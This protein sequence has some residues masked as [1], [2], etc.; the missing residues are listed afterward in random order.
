MSHENHYSSLS[1][2][3]ESVFKKELMD[4]LPMEA[5]CVPLTTCNCQPDSLA[6]PMR[7]IPFRFARRPGNRKETARFLGHR[8]GD[9]LT[10]PRTL[11]CDTGRT[12]LTLHHARSKCTSKETGCN[13]RPFAGRIP[14]SSHNPKRSLTWDRGLEMAG[15]GK[16]Y[17]SDGRA[18]LLCDP[19]SPWQHGTKETPSAAAANIFLEAPT[20]PDSQ[21]ALDHVSRRLNDAQESIRFPDSC[22]ETHA[23]VAST[24]PE[25]ADRNREK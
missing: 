22:R 2:K 7:R 21:S 12:P 9:L 15:T 16:T 4:R 1:F 17:R 11:H 3:R 25:L 5:A 10:A 24:A 13:E 6:A 8:E 19:Q 14:Q 23:N 20:C 18:G